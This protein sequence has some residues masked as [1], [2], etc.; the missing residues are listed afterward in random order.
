[1]IAEMKALDAKIAP[2][3]KLVGPYLQLGEFDTAFRIMFASLDRDRL[4]WLHEWDLAHAWSA[5]SAAWRRDP[6]F[7]ELA[8]RIG[9]VDYWKQYGFPDGCRSGADKPIECT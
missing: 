9:L 1:M 6:R 3:E 7:G 2:Q 5:D 4:A 8:E